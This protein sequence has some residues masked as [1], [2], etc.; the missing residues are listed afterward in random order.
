MAEVTEKDVLGALATVADPDRKKDIVSLGMVSGLT[1]KGGHV[2]F[3]IEVDAER[4]PRLEPLRKAAEK[5]VDA[6]PGVLTVS[7]VLTAERDGHAGH[8]HDHGHNHDHD[9]DH[10]HGGHGHAH[11]GHGGRGPAPGQEEPL[12]PGVKTIIAVASGKGGV[13]K[14]TTAV[15]LALALKSR[16]LSVGMFDADIFGPSQPRMLGVSG[17]QPVSKD[18]ES[19]EAVEAYGMK[20]MSIGF[21]VP[22]DSPV[23]WRGPMVMGAL[24]QMMRQ[25][26]WGELDVLIV[27][28]PPGTGDTQLTMT[29]R[30]PL[31]GAVIV[32][33]PQDIALLDARKGL[34]MFRQ[35]NV[36]VLGI[37]ENMSYYN[38]PNCG[39]EAHIFGHGG[40][41]FE[42]VRLSTDFLGEL[43]LDIDI[44]TTS[45]DGRP[46]VVSQPDGPLALAYKAIAEKLWDK[47]Q[48]LQ[49]AKKGP[50]IVMQ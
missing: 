11:G 7:V 2:S 20:V 12:M 23:V 39:H 47:V 19:M 42:A 35:V 10:G 16:G 22:E 49:S 25:V 33:T 3:A 4:G 24:E 43:P 46:I 1:L 6:L 40:A 34:N 18:G 41:K 14:S 50:K 38:C 13:G 32:S 36:P 37:I 8:G 17:A 45:D 5:A 27:D 15:N 48:L 28:M 9:H 31:T 29:Q 44:R 21:L 30:V 26:N